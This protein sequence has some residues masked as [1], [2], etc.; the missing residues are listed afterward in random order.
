MK[1]RYEKL[2]KEHFDRIYNLT[3]T[4][5]NRPELAEDMTQETFMRAYK[6]LANFRGDAQLSTWLYRIALNVC[7]STMKKESRYQYPDE[8][9]EPSWEGTEERGPTPSAEHEYLERDRGLQLRTAIQQLK[10]LQADAITL[11]YLREYSYTEVADI[12]DLPLNTVKSHL[13]RAKE[14]LRSI[15]SEVMI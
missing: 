8:T 11:Y 12:M 5:C 1:S 6:G 14:K 2:V 13:R 15:L 10:P 4:R 7:H 3:L 9:G